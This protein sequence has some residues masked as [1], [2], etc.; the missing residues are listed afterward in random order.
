MDE[1]NF[2]IL[3]DYL[4]LKQK[5]DHITKQ[6][7][8]N[9]P[10]LLNHMR[11]NL[12]RDTP[13]SDEARNIIQNDK[14]VEEYL[15]KNYKVMFFFYKNKYEGNSK[16]ISLTYKKLKQILFELLEKAEQETEGDYII[17]SQYL[18]DIYAC[19]NNIYKDS[20]LSLN[21]IKYFIDNYKNMSNIEIDELQN[22]LTNTQ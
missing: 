5:I 22:D 1:Y 10:R 17:I 12:I 2:C 6:Y 21:H 3:L 20:L 13:M 4:E 14:F 11:K 7:D 19:I 16:I 18:K 15:L 8:D 9:T